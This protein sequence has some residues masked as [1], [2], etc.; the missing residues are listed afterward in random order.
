VLANERVRKDGE[1]VQGE[2]SSLEIEKQSLTR[3]QMFINI[4]LGV[5]LM[6]TKVSWKPA[7]KGG[8]ILNLF[9]REPLLRI[10]CP[11]CNDMTIVR[12]GITLCCD[13]PIKKPDTYQKKR[14]C[15]AEHR[16]AYVSIAE[17]EMILGAQ[18]NRCFYCDERLDGVTIKLGKLVPLK[19]HFDHVVAWKFSG[20]SRSVNLVASCHICNQIK[21]DLLFET[22]DEA[23]VY[24]LHRRGE[25]GYEK[26]DYED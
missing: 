14:I 18:G 19:I 24:I 26:Y 2:M 16:R 9:G 3:N 11:K 21:H 13:A 15:D 17:K 5:I 22:S 1:R 4:P 7:K 23:R 6:N 10:R 25:L 12:D 20:D 8:A